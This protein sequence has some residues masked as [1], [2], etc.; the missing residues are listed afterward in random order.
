MIKQIIISTRNY[1]IIDYVCNK[2]INTFK[3][4][5]PNNKKY[6]LYHTSFRW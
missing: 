4:Y 5:L 1:I 3:K 6:V 2:K